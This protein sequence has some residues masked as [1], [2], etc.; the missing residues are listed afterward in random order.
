MSSSNAIQGRALLHTAQHAKTHRYECILPL[1]MNTK[2]NHQL[3]PQACAAGAQDTECPHGRC[4]T[5]RA[6]HTGWMHIQQF[7]GTFTETYLIA[8]KHTGA[9][10]PARTAHRHV[11]CTLLVHQQV[12]VF[13][14]RLLTGTTVGR[15]PANAG[16]TCVPA[17]TA[18]RCPHAPCRVGTHLLSPAC[19]PCLHRQGR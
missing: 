3:P 9:C 4:C 19:T 12:L 13:P 8:S 7:S 5:R 1:Y 11:W 16:G 14:L 2:H 18:E 17:A 15:C 10:T 6:Q